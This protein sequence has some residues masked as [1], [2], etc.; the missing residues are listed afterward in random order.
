MQHQIPDAASCITE[1]RR[2]ATGFPEQT[3]AHSVERRRARPAERARG[4]KAGGAHVLPVGL[5][6]RRTVPVLEIDAR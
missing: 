6:R 4:A 3:A 2:V 1:L 5:V